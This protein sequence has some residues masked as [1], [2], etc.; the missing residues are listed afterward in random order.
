MEINRSA[1]L[2][3]NFP[4]LGGRGGRGGGGGAPDSAVLELF[5]ATAAGGFTQQKRNYEQQ[6]AKLADFCE[7]ARRY[8]KVRAA[9]APGFL[10][11]LKLEA[12]IPVLERKLPLAVS[13][14]NATGIHD[15]IAFAEKQNVKIVI[16]QPRDLSKVGA[17]LKAKNVPVI[18]GRVLA[19]PDQEDD[20]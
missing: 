17:E 5:G 4:R 18:L 8:Q 3:V 15:A 19:L 9:N 13:A 2:H 16:M 14:R 6:I 12:M 10:R 7:E 1:A 20:P 11:D